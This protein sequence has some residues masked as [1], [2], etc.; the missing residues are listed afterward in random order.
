VASE[1][2]Y[3]GARLREKLRGSWRVWRHRW[4]L[5]GL[6]GITEERFK[7]WPL[8]A[9]RGFIAG[10]IGA[11]ALV[12][13]TPLSGFDISAFGAF[14]IFVA[15]YVPSWNR[16][17]RWG[18]FVIPLTFL[19]L[20]AGYPEYGFNDD[21]TGKLFTIPVLGAFPNV[22]TA[23]VMLIFVMMAVGLNVV[24]GY[25]G[26]LDLG[27]VAF[28]AIG[29]YTGAVLAS[30]QFAGQNA[31]GTPK[32]FFNFGGVDIDKSL[33]GIH[34]SVW[35]LLIVAGLFTSLLGMLIGLPTL[36]LRGDYLAIVTLGF[37][38]ILPQIARNGD[39]FFNTGINVTNGPQG[40]TSMDGIGFGSWIHRHISILPSNYLSASNPDELFF[41]TAICLVL[42]TI[43]CSL[44]LRDSKLGRAWI[45]IREDETA[46]AAMGVPLMRTKT[47]A[48][49]MGAVFAGV[50]GAYYAE[51]NTG[52]QPDAFAFQFSVA[53]L[54][55][56]ILGGVGNVWG[57]LVGAA[58]LAYLDQQGLAD[59]GDWLNR[60]LN[61]AIDVP[62]YEYGIFGVFLLVMMLFRPHGLIPEARHK[63]EFEEG[64]SDEPLYDVT[65]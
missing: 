23:V 65:Q 53:V 6:V 16:L 2:L 52:A 26:L 45:A 42:I 51:V 5:L 54:V 47:L 34:I 36:R 1:Q 12:I 39:N 62:K 31:Q 38:E 55:M 9:Q 56:V 4:A 15:L 32:R 27:Y 14:L 57:V 33:G 63:L 64:V 18:R 49:A 58:F 8:P 25:A 40:V 35:L 3:P 43:F 11:L 50:A 48:Y 29:A 7:S 28:Y 41:W 37:G 59:T 46:A 21:G 10:L 19:A 20:V 17:G 13:L 61:I 22:H 30:T 44:R 60:H 24:V